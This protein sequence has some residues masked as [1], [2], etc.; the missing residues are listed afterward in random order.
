MPWHEAGTDWTEKTAAELRPVIVSLCNAVGDRYQ[1][2]GLDRPEWPVNLEQDIAVVDA[3]YKGE[4]LEEADLYG[5]DIF[6]YGWWDLIAG[7][8][9]ALINRGTLILPHVSWGPSS[10]LCGG[11]SKTATGSG[12]GS[13]LWTLEELET[14]VGMG[15]INY[16]SVRELPGIMHLFDEVA[17]N[18]LREFLNRL[19]YPVLF[20]HDRGGDWT[21]LTTEG[22]DTSGLEA[23]EDAAASAGWA[24]LGDPGNG[25]YAWANT[26]G[27]G[28]AFG[29]LRARVFYN[30][31][32]SRAEKQ[33]LQYC[34]FDWTESEGGGGYLGEITMQTHVMRLLGS[35]EGMDLSFLGKDVSLTGP[36]S[37]DDMSITDADALSGT[38]GREAV[39]VTLG[40]FAD[41][42]DSPFSGSGTTD[43]V[44][45]SGLGSMV[46]YSRCMFATKTDRQSFTFSGDGG[47]SQSTRLILDITAH[48]SDQ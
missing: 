34:V 45:F 12:H 47:R 41:S 3:G 25:D 8:I 4:A 10:S 35:T 26:S 28:G 16:S 31:T 11:W 42:P 46:A 27:G 19:L 48:C 22:Y 33:L 32:R 21:D 15:V 24:D 9:S 29:E 14:D 39:A 30:G 2:I 40:N 5:L 6:R 1:C 44:D 38:T 20:P 18:R 23:A 36:Y 37:L 7:R 43:G 13:D 17:P